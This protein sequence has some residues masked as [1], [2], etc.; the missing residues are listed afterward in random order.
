MPLEGKLCCIFSGTLFNV[1]DVNVV[2]VAAVTRALLVNLG[3]KTHLPTQQQGYFWPAKSFSLHFSVLFIRLAYTIMFFPTILKKRLLH[4]PI[5]THQGD[6]DG[7]NMPTIVS[8]RIQRM[9]RSLLK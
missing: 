2:N 7:E 6:G 5:K 4:W 3:S 1:K 8:D 9:S